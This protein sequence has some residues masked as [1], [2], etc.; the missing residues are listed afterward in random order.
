MES[1]LVD[2]AWPLTLRRFGCGRKDANDEEEWRSGRVLQD[3]QLREDE[4][5]PDAVEVAVDSASTTRVISRHT[6][7]SR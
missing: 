5:I 3:V 6:G 1:G 7:R 4:G 2:E